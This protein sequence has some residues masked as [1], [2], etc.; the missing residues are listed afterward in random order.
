MIDHRVE[1]LSCPLPLCF[2]A[3]GAAAAKMRGTRGPAALPV[4]ALVHAAH[5][6]FT[7]GWGWGACK[8][9]GLG[10]CWQI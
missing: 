3:W 9:G 4:A 5:C 6:H 8:V 7:G 10:I 2:S 1:A